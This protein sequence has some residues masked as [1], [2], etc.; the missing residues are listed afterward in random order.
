MHSDYSDRGNKMKKRKQKKQI[1]VRKNGNTL[2]EGNIIDLPIK[3][4]F[5]T[6]RSIE[7]FDDDDPCIIH[8]S[9]VIKDFQ[10]KLLTT[11]KELNTTVLE[12]KSNIE[13]LEVIDFNNTEEIIFE[14]KE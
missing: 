10:D 5:I 12:G 7:L 11:Y 4:A 14:L 6:Q 3:D 13:I 1:I 8:K 2:F 9:Y